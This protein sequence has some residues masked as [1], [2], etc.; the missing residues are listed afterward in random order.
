[1][2]KHLKSLSIKLIA[3]S[4]VFS[5]GILT[6]CVERGKPIKKQQKQAKK[7]KIA[8]Y[9]CPNGHEGSDQQGKCVDCNAV[10]LHN[11]AYHG[12]NIPQNAVHDPFNSVATP[13]NSKPA[14]AQNKY[15]DYHYIC[16]NGHPGGAAT[17]QNCMTCGTKLTHNKLYHR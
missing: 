9:I 4:F 5:P 2:E 3:L 15:G 14:P 8:H 11:E 13:N 12:L 17:N 1:M 7:G 16:P 6:S 10:L